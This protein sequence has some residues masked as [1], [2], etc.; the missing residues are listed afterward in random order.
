MKAARVNLVEGTIW[1]SLVLYALPLLLSNFLQQL[2]NTAD[3]LIVGRFAGSHA[4][5][6]VGAIGSV[7]GM[8][9]GLA[10]GLA[11]GCTVVVSQYF[12]AEDYDGLYRTVHTA[13]AIA[14]GGG[15]ILSAAGILL[16]PVL[17]QAMNTPAE[18]L[19]GAVLYMRV[20]FAGIIPSLIYNMGAGILNAVGD[21]RRPF[22]FLLVSAVTNV[23]FDLL[24]VAIIPW[25][26][27]GA[28]IATVIA[29]V[30][31]AGLVLISLT[32]TDS[33]YRVFLRD[34]RPHMAVLKKVSRIGLPAGTQSVL[35]SLSNTFIQAAIN[36]FGA[37]AVAGVAVANRVDGFIFVVMNAIGLSAMTFTGQN[38]GA[39]KP[40]R[41]RRGLYISAGMVV[42]VSVSLGWL[43]LGFAPQIVSLFNDDPEVIA[44]TIR[45]MSFILPIYFVFGLND[46]IGGFLRGRG[47][48]LVPML[49]SLIFMT[50]AR[51]L[52]IYIATPIW[53]SIDVIF[54]AYPI[55]W[56]LTFIVLFIYLLKTYG[57]RSDREE[58]KALDRL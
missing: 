56:I 31:A 23:V 16:A 26:V 9:V 34:I 20:Y 43:V 42:L 33:P 39:G 54:M 52:W 47:K 53:P 30:V 14:L 17:L 10:V 4:M 38:V 44:Y 36:G 32:R 40:E 25:G 55:T 45:M 8:L 50:G 27:A 28:A 18:I 37:K 48:S 58:E 2:Y 5:G 46:V 7:T 6:S 11:T 41:V 1:R 15:L 35:V 3:L 21:S 12:G 51:L 29:Q 49:I 13:M 24:F 57:F 22:Y 19:P